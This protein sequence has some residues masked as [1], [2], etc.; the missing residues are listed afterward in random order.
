MSKNNI[1]SHHHKAIVN[2]LKIYFFRDK[3]MALDHMK[4]LKKIFTEYDFSLRYAENY[5]Y[6]IKN[7]TNSEY[8]DYT[9]IVRSNL[10]D[11]C[12]DPS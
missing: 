8:Y 5:G 3:E 9:G 4:T 7:L 11:I 10:D 1:H 12:T 2:G 6:L